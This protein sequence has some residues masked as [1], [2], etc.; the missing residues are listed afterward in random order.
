MSGPVEG[1]VTGWPGAFGLLMVATATWVGNPGIL[2]AVPLGLLAFLMA[3]RRPMALVVGTVALALAVLGTPTSG[4]GYLERGWA[5]LL[6]GWFVA[7]SLRWPEGR[8]L[9]RGLG[10]VVGSFLGMGLLLAVRPGE[11]TVV[12]WLVKSRLEL[13]VTT[14]LQSARTRV[15]PEVVSEAFETSAF[16]LLNLQGLVYP[17]LLGLASLSAL[18]VAWWL[19]GRLAKRSGAVLGTLP[20]FRFND[21]LVWV[22]IF[23]IIALVMS[24]GAVERLGVNAVVFMGAL[25][26]LRGA[27]VVL[28]LTGGLSIFGGLLAFVGFI[29][30][31]PFVVTGAVFIGLGDTWFDLRNRGSVPGSEA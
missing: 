15:G 29:F 27:A 20:D 9:P 4:F 26:A 5:L 19:F 14:F 7:L 16:D 30:L 31:A 28:F 18:G 12:D 21:Q 23:G 22:L 8:F 3:P 25:Y 6:G 24:S 11:W 13:A 2:V 10:A 17:A 1:R